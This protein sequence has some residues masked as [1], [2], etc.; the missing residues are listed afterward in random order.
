M[1]NMGNVSGG[2]QPGQQAQM[3]P[4]GG[5]GR[6]SFQMGMPNSQGVQQGGMPQQ[7]GFGSPMQTPSMQQGQFAQ[8]NPYSQLLFPQQNNPNFSSNAP[9]GYAPQ[10]PAIGGFGQPQQSPYQ[11][12]QQSTHS[13]Y[14]GFFGSLGMSNVGNMGSMGS[15]GG[16]GVGSMGGMGGMG[17]SGGT[18][19][20]GTLGSMGS[21]G[22]MN[23][24]SGGNMGGFG[25]M[26][27][28]GNMNAIQNMADG[29]STNEQQSDPWGGWAPGQQAALSGNAGQQYSPS[30]WGYG[31]NGVNFGQNYANAF[32][33]QQQQNSNPGQLTDAALAQFGQNPNMS[34]EDMQKIVN[35]SPGTPS[36]SMTNNLGY[37]QGLNPNQLG[38]LQN[39]LSGP[40]GGTS[41][42]QNPFKVNYGTPGAALGPIGSSDAPMR[43]MNDA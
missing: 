12:G 1:A 26:S 21:M 5:G 22:S 39:Y 9:S 18:G 41:L 37:Y 15:V 3:G 35:G 11:G 19:A 2:F 33:T 6:A 10:Q 28:A 36:M 34:Q 25:N 29:G 32:Q 16:M 14:Q 23:G 38:N 27:G 8:Q 4:Q 13:P 43:N 31:Q 42:M 20:A 24:P 30:N 7:S 40:A 17:S